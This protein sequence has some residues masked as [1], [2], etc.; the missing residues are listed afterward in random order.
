MV[1]FAGPVIAVAAEIFKMTL[2]LFVRQFRYRIRYKTYMKRLGL[3]VDELKFTRKYVE[4]NIERAVR[5]LGIITIR[6]QAWLEKVNSETDRYAT[7]LGLMNGDDEAA[8]VC[9]QC[10]GSVRYD[11]G[12]EA[13]KKIKHVNELIIEGRSFESVSD[14]PSLCLDRIFFEKEK[15]IQ[16]RSAEVTVER[17]DQIELLPAVNQDIV[18]LPSR[19]FTM[20]AVMTALKD[21]NILLVGIYGMGGVGKTTLMTQVWKQVIE[22]KLF[23]VVVMITVTKDIDLKKIQVDIANRFGLTRLE[24][25]DDERRRAAKL[26]ERLRRDAINVLV[27]LDDLWTSR[28]SLSSDVGI[29]CG[30]DYNHPFKVA[31][32][33][34]DVDI[35]QQFGAHNSL[36]SR[37]KYIEVGVLSENDSMLLFRHNVGKGEQVYSPSAQEIVAECSGL[38]LALVTLGR[39]MINKSKF[40]WESTASDLK[41]S[42][43]TYLGGMRS[44]VSASIQ[45]SYHHLE[46]DIHKRCFLFCCLFQKNCQIDIDQLVMYVLSDEKIVADLRT[47]NE[48]RGRIQTVLDRLITSCLL[49]SYT[50]KNNGIV[51]SVTMHG[52]VRDVA[53]NIAREEGNGFYASEQ[54][55]IDWEM[56]MNWSRVSLVR[57]KIDEL[58]EEPPALP[59]LLVL[60]LQQNPQLKRI[61]DGFF[62][63]MDAL[64]SLDISKTGI[65]SLPSSLSLLVNLLSLCLDYCNFGDTATANLS[66]VG[67]LRKLE[68]LSLVECC[69]IYLPDAIGELHN[70]KSL[71]L[72]Y[73]YRLIIPPN[74]I[75]R[76]YGLEELY[77]MN[78][79]RKWEVEDRITGHGATLEEVASRTS[80]KTLHLMKENEN[81]ALMLCISMGWQASGKYFVQNYDGIADQFESSLKA[82]SPPFDESIKMLLARVGNLVISECSGLLTVGELIA[83]D[84][85]TK[86][87]ALLVVK[88]LDMEF[89]MNFSEKKIPESTFSVNMKQITHGPMPEEFFDKL[90]LM[91]LLECEELVC[92][93]SPDTLAKFKN[94]EVLR[95]EKCHKLKYGFFLGEGGSEKLDVTF[96][97]L[98]EIY[99]ETLP[100]LEVIWKGVD[101]TEN[102]GKLKIME[103]KSCNVLA[104][105]FTSSMV[106]AL[107]QLERL[108]IGNCESMGSIVPMEEDVTFPPQIFSNLRELKIQ[109]CHSLKNLYPLTNLSPGG[110][111]PNL[112]LLEVNDCD[113]LEAILQVNQDAQQ[114]NIKERYVF[115]QLEQLFLYN[116][117]SLKDILKMTSKSFENLKKVHVEDCNSMKH[118][119]PMSLLGPGGLPKL[120]HIYLGDCNK[121]ESIFYDDNHGGKKVKSAAEKKLAEQQLDR[122][123]CSSVKF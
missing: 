96:P 86:M 93:F 92:L 44:K 104:Y 83:D 49:L 55:R 10:F 67:N 89:L 24:E 18:L 47:L 100:K 108:E 88:C 114:T 81:G 110:Q 56:I 109:Q 111:L 22:E 30:I 64:V 95:V 82:A 59:N 85:F 76:L 84:G 70:L 77:T 51:S 119:L 98:S 40:V 19:N 73:N 103:V 78:S 48:V 42:K 5:N 6:V 27:I 122:F 79:F 69:L 74:V 29:P 54:S 90:K 45:L 8:Q 68:I 11:I 101:S 123:D 33:T 43:V 20:N 21:K 63:S 16:N 120:E 26:L 39:A 58:P 71:D 34:R 35:C 118:L 41:N 121:M 7:L 57:N 60:S 94:L 13:F 80:L 102:F 31:I 23:D 38:P 2:P 25:L 112:Q 53:L 106:S 91:E 72:S 116:L 14:Y 107:Q 75:S 12:K 61:P 1:A 117:P 99:F 87:R 62:R 115:P 17:L 66:I 32:T 97:E 28:L 3:K 65:R 9:V 50:K 37:A 15:F 105:L 36:A 113:K 4:L 52:M 46:D